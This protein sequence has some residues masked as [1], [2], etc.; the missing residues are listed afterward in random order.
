[1][2]S[3][4]LQRL[5]EI[6]FRKAATVVQRDLS[7]PRLGIVTITRVKLSRDFES[8]RIWWSCLEEGGARTATNAA[9]E[10]ARPFLQREIAGALRLRK[11]P[12]IT[13]QFDDAI[14]GIDRMARLIRA[15]RDEDEARQSA[16]GEAGTEQPEPGE[17]TQEPP[18]AD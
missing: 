5:E 13:L 18:A 11:A 8:C 9:L 2:P 4:S 1:M 6:I 17:P 3:R 14:E 15:A 12:L 7:D 16:R 10:A